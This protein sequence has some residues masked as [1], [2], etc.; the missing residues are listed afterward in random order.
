MAKDTDKKKY[1]KWLK[2]QERLLRQI[3]QLVYNNYLSMLSIAGVKK[4]ITTGNGDFFFA[5]NDTANKEVDKLLTAMAK[6]MDYLLLNGIEREWKQGQESFWDKLKLTFSKTARDQKAFDQIRE[7]ATQSNRDKTAQSFYNEKREN[8]LSVSDR[9]WNLAGNA[10]KEMEI[11]I[12]NGIKEGKSAD[13]IQKSLKGYLNE[14]DKLFKRVRNK[15]TGELELSKAAQKYKPGRGVYR[16]AYKNAMRLARTEL[17]A[18]NCEAAWNSAQNNPLITGWKI[19]LSNNHT[20]LING[21]PTPFKDICDK[22]QGVYPKTFKFKGWH[23]QCRCEMLPIT[24]TQAESKDLYKS[25]FDGKRDQWKPEQ[26]TKTP[27]AF[28]EW[29]QQNQERAK[30]WA[31]MP[32]FIKDNRQFVKTKFDVDTYTAEE[33]KFTQARKTQEAMQRVVEQLEKLYPDIP[34]TELAAIH[35][36][37]KSGGNYRQLNKQMEKGTLT[38]FNRAAQTL[39]RQGLEKAPIY[40]GTVYRGMIVKRTDFERAFAGEKGDIIRHNRFVSSSMDVGIAKEFNSYRGLKKGEIQV[41]FE[42]HSK[43]GRDISSMS[44]KNGIFDPK[45]QKEVLFMN[46]TAFEITDRYTD[47]N[48]VVYIKLK[49]R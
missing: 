19:V 5:H 2:E 48:G 13:D 29:V 16:S 37:T 30:G 4:A 10:K 8:G 41:F 9:V 45:N 27:K 34:N 35:H 23:P 40:N 39:I 12:Q 24:I 11:I 26:I 17:K 7:K 32:R 38:D 1:K 42:I 46:N 22:L 43:T 18:A 44:E 36:Y 28:D 6:R 20:T 15:D 33:K 31:N 25:I 47:S 21:V 14:P 3:Q 49:E